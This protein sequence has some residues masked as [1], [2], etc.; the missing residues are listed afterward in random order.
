MTDH[1][2]LLMMRT[3]EPHPLIQQHLAAG[4]FDG[5]AEVLVLF[6][7]VGELV[8]VRAPHQSL[9][10]DTALGGLAEQLGDGRAAVAHLLV[11]VTAPVGE[12][13]VVAPTERLD[14]GHQLVE[15][16]RAVDQRLRPIAL[17]PGGQVWC[18][19]LPRSASVRNQSASSD[20]RP[21]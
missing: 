9:D 3:A 15:V 1:H 11:G 14:L 5:L 6:L 13:Q 8:Q 10:D 4:P 20:T 18:A 16:R 17:T 7:A 12:E 21:R 2:Q 19:G